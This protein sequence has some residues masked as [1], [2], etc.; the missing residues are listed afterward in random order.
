M[1]TYDAWTKKGKIP[2]KPVKVKNTPEIRNLTK[3][4]VH[5]YLMGLGS[6]EWEDYMAGLFIGAVKNAKGRWVDITEM[7]RYDLY[8]EDDV[9]VYCKKQKDV[10]T[11]LIMNFI[12][13]L[14]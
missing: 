14:P 1:T 10:A 4:E 2:P 8:G 11:F 13:K 6:F 7:F 3:E 5:K 12:P 9:G